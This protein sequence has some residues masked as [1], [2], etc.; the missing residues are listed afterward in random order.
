MDTFLENK[1]PEFYQ[2]FQK[3]YFI[4]FDL[5]IITEKKFFR[6][7]RLIFM[8]KN[9]CDCTNFSNFEEVVHNFGRFD[10]D[11]I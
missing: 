7:I 3:I 2:S 11:M 8:P 1:I 5:L 4:T 9:D 10:D 6:K